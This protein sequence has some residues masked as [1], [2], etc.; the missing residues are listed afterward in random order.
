MWCRLLSS[1]K[2]TTPIIVV[3]DHDH[4]V[5][6]KPSQCLPFPPNSGKY[7]VARD[8]VEVNKF[9]RIALQNKI[10]KLENKAGAIADICRYYK[11]RFEDI[12]GLPPAS[13]NPSSFV[14]HFGF[15]SK[16]EAIDEKSSMG[17]IACAVLSQDVKMLGWLHRAGAPLTTRLN[18]M[19]SVAV[20]PGWTPLHLAAQLSLKNI[21]PLKE[22]LWWRASP[23]VMDS[24]GIPVLAACSSRDA[25]RLLVDHR[26]DVNLRRSPSFKSALQGSCA[27]FNPTEAVAELIECRAHVHPGEL[28]TLAMD[29]AMQKNAVEL[30]HLLLQ[31]KAEVNA[32]PPSPSMHRLTE[33]TCRAWVLLG[34]QPP[35]SVRYLAES[36]SAALGHASFWGSANL[37]SFLLGARAD[38]QQCNSRGH[39][40]A[41]LA[42]H[43]RM[44]DVLHSFSMKGLADPVHTCEELSN[45]A[46]SVQLDF[47][48]G[49][50]FSRRPSETHGPSVTHA[51]SDSFSI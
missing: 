11:A 2:T 7:S 19:T 47:W 29:A 36:S 12:L 32:R 38:P 41:Q 17:A 5:F 21:G 20:P 44:A 50:R 24:S 26:A 46:G 22:L 18:A 13:R 33:L 14:S 35:V 1:R 25:V 37:A 43:H 9:I 8:R 3:L 23:N 34:S 45:P 42:R 51:A 39:K 10:N 48:M 4:A 6:A 16:E 40:P 49:R 15:P 31:F 30:A 27:R 28:C